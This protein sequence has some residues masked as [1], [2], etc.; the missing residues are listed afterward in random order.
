M[1]RVP[2]S[3]IC[4]Q[5]LMSRVPESGICSQ[6]LM[7]RVPESGICPQ[8]L[9][10]RVPESGICPQRLMSRVPERSVSASCP[11]KLERSVVEK[12]LICNVMDRSITPE[13]RSDCSAAIFGNF[14]YWYMVNVYK[15]LPP[16]RTNTLY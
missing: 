10:S 15:T 4:P 7:S 5:R 3:G 14:S 2:E 8:R 1:S 16:A 9:M 12:G 11:V 6:R 13:T